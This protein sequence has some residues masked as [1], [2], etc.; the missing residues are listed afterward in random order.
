MGVN[1]LKT[2]VRR[3]T[4]ERTPTRAHIRLHAL[5]KYNNQDFVVENL[6]KKVCVWSVYVPVP[7]RTSA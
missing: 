1:E 5:P 3:S 4:P 6:G 2:S 7:D